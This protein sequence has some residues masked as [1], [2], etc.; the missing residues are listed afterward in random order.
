MQPMCFQ[1]LQESDVCLLY[2]KLPPPTP[3]GY[4][5][6]IYYSGGNSSAVEINAW[7]NIENHSFTAYVYVFSWTGQ[8]LHF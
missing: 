6:L 7:V 5:A 4:T 3:T 2:L 8:F 1:L